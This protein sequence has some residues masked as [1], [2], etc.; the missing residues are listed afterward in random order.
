MINIVVVGLIKT[1][2]ANLANTKV[3]REVLVVFINF[4]RDLCSQLFH[5]PL[6]IPH[7]PVTFAKTKCGR[8]LAKDFISLQVSNI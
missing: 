6:I 4:P 3:K 8:G 1:K 7:V 5:S 2:L